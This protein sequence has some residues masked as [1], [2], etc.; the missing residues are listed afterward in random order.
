[1][2]DFDG[3]VA[4][5]KGGSSGIGAATSQVMLDRGTRVAVLDRNPSPN[6]HVL[7]APCDITDPVSVA[8]AVRGVV[9]EYGQ[10]DVVVNNAGIG[11]IGD[12]AAND[13][14]EWRRVFDI[15]VFSAV[16]VSRETL[17]HL[18]ASSHA[19]IV[20]TCSIVAKTGVPQ[21]ALYSASKGEIEALTLAMAVDH[22][23]EGIRQRRASRDGGHARGGA[24]AR[25]Q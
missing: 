12:V 11:A 17:P 8:S 21:R 15:N 13:D 1:M 18:R 6:E 20:N 19:S 16:Q 14:D 5:V 7:F 10:L 25:E 22:V 4:V 9:A 23:S 24:P 2:K 3:L